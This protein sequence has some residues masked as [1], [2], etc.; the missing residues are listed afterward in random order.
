MF[1]SL[2]LRIIFV[3]V[4][5]GLYSCRTANGLA[6]LSGESE[7]GGGGN[8]ALAS[9]RID[10][11]ELSSMQIANNSVWKFVV[12]SASQSIYFVRW[13]LCLESAAPCSNFHQSAS[14]VVLLADAAEGRNVVS[15]QLC[16]DSNPA[17]CGDAVLKT[18]EQGPIPDK[19]L[20]AELATIESSKGAIYTQTLALVAAAQKQAL[21]DP[22]GSKP[23]TAAL[24]NIHAVG[25]APLAHL[26]TMGALPKVE[27][28]PQEKEQRASNTGKI[29]LAF[30]VPLIVVG[31]LATVGV[32]YYYR[33]EMARIAAL[34]KLQVGVEQVASALHTM[35]VST[36]QDQAASAVAGESEKIASS[37][38]QGQGTL[39]DVEASLRRTESMQTLS[40]KSTHTTEEDLRD[41]S[42]LK[43]RDQSFSR[44]NLLTLQYPLADDSQLA[45]I[46]AQDFSAK[47]AESVLSATA[48][49]DSPEVAAATAQIKQTLAPIPVGELPVPRM[50]RPQSPPPESIGV[51]QKKLAGERVAL[52]PHR[53]VLPERESLAPSEG[54]RSFQQNL[55]AAHKRT[56]GA[57]AVAALTVL[58]LGTTLTAEGAEQL[59][60]ADAQSEEHDP[61]NFAATLKRIYANLKKALADQ[62]AASA[63]IAHLVAAQ[64]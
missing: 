43:A 42:S 39:T 23:E 41:V 63:A 59:T 8:A 19:A 60:S 51:G 40:Q 55:E 45:A 12:N 3:L 46:D 17:L 10:Q 9:L 20:Q 37:I 25:A 49:V 22:S 2:F 16:L 62:A 52:Q 13:S 33:S 36:A 54:S 24:K 48:R 56:A 61:A 53:A 38:K 15:V 44:R 35:P 7:A 29:L 1:A 32:V 47:P 21:T 18:F 26:I 5:L 31:L 27:S 4:A 64:Q 14:T 6:P 50:K 34:E 30:G 28:I 57:A 58:T 11:L